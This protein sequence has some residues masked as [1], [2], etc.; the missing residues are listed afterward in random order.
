MCSPGKYIF[1]LYCGVLGIGFYVYWEIKA[2]SFYT[3]YKA[4][5]K[6]TFI[7]MNRGLQ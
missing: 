5:Q 7:R 3:L 2:R 4:H 6:Q 1:L